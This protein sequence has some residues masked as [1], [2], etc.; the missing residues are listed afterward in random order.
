MKMSLCCC[1]AGRCVLFAAMSACLP[2]V[3]IG[4]LQEPDW[5]SLNAESRAR[6]LV[7]VRA[8]RPGGNPFWNGYAK[9]FIHPP[10]F[11]F[12]EVAEEREYGFTLRPEGGGTSVVWSAAAPW[13]PV[14]TNAWDA[15][16]PGYYVLESRAMTMPD[17]WESRRFYRAAVFKGPYPAAVRTYRESARMVYASVFKNPCV[18]GWLSS[19]DPPEGYDLYCYPTKIISSLVRALCRH[20]FVAPADKDESMDIARRMADWLIAH[21]Q[22]AGSP[23][24]GFPPTYWGE[25]REVS[26][27]NAGQNML[28]YPAQAA[29]AYFDL[30]KA[31]GDKRYEVAALDIA[32]GYVR[33]QEADGTWPLKVRESDGMPVRANRLVPGRYV[34]GMFDRAFA[35]TGNRNFADAGERAFGYV[36][37][38]PCVTWNWDGQFE[39]M[40]PMPPYRNLQKGNAADTSIRLFEV[41]RVDLAREIVDWCEDQFVVWSDPVHNMDWKHW[42]TPTAL[43]QYDYYTP[44]DASMADMIGAFTAAYRKTGER[45]YLE[46]AKAL[47]DNIT[48]HQRPDGTIPTYFDSRKGSDWLNCMIY[49]A[50]RLEFLADAIDAK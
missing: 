20:A 11:D 2:A 12:R 35:V 37:D 34:L 44:I 24:A 19:K 23:L 42:K 6:S 10:S 9:A 31:T 39:D 21:S 26:I 8:G 49:V 29:L 22:S 28:T 41:G 3:V 17:F 5:T 14:P 32:H 40:E 45:L 33:L 46:K 1:A 38:N 13:T 18:K 47:A 15:L 25:R 7:Q 48:R 36:L 30:A 16:P 27:R 43:E 50:D 4:A